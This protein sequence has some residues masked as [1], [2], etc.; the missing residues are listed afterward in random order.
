MTREA[1]PDIKR[2]TA[3]SVLWSLAGRG[4]TTLTSFAIF[5]LLARLLTPSEFGLFAL[6]AVFVDVTRI[7]A[8]SGWTDAVVRASELDEET[9][10]TAFWSNLGF[11]VLVAVIAALVAIPY[12]RITGQPMVAQLLWWLA[13]LVPLSCLGSIHMGQVLHGFGYRSMAMRMFVANVLAGG[14]AVAAAW[15]GWG[16][17]S[18]IVQAV[19]ADVANVVTAWFACPWMP[20]RKFSIARFR[21]LVGFTS[22]MMVTQL[23]WLL[24]ARTP[25]LFI[26]RSLG[27]AALGAY[28]IG[29]RMF[30]MIGQLVLQPVASVGITTFSRLRADPAGVER[31]YLRIVGLLAFVIFPVMGGFGAVAPEAIPLLFGAK[32]TSSIGVAQILMGLMIPYLLSFF[33]GPIFGAAG[34]ASSLTKIAALQLCLTL[35]LSWI[36]APWGLLVVA[37]AYVLR[38]FMTLPFQQYLIWR[39]TGIRAGRIWAAIVRPLLAS[40][41]MV[42]AVTIM[43]PVLAPHVG[44]Q[45]ALLVLLVATGALAYSALLLLIAREAILSQLT[46]V[47]PLLRRAEAVA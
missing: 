45:L 40:L 22:S 23:L 28:R 7:I 30:E 17:W 38:S 2:R 33:D 1:A 26:A 36:S 41:G 35:L 3:V 32:W 43:R 18:L 16:V 24:L 20:G 21:S 34:R 29:F 25:D 13:P 11:G 5:L 47:R 10:D 12:A 27:P 19:V 14:A 6:A 8:M 44:S 9:L 39:D 4:S 42:I 15:A 31:A 37:G 46:F